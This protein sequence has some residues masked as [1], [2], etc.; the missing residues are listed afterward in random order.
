MTQNIK[1]VYYVSFDSGSLHLQECQI[2]TVLILLKDKIKGT[3][4]V[5][6]ETSLENGHDNKTIPGN[7]FCP[8]SC[9]STWFLGRRVSRHHYHISRQERN[10][11][12]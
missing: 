2:P 6:N 12:S 7:P 5:E 3:R 8:L 1:M 9:R 11:I 10:N 4:M